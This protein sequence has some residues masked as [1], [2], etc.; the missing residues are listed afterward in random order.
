MSQVDDRQ[1]IIDEKEDI[2]QSESEKNEAA[3]EISKA[4]KDSTAN[5]MLVKVHSPFKSYFDGDAFSISAENLVGPFDVLPGHHNFIT[6]LKACEISIRSN[7][8]EEKI[9][10]SGGIMHVKAD[11]VI[12]FLDV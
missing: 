9:N 8:G 1:E 3:L 12:V 6:L 10:V 2:S 11:K 5:S 4:N 7:K